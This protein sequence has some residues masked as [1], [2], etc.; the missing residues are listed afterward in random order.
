MKVTQGLLSL[1]LLAPAMARADGPSWKAQAKA[2]LVATTGN[3]QTTTL[4]MGATASRADD[5]NKFAV[6]GQLAYGR[7]GILVV[8]DD[9]D[10]V[11][12]PGEISRETRT[13]ANAWTTKARYD[14]TFGP[15]HG[16]FVAA[17]LGADAP[18]GKDL[19]SGGQAGYTQRLRKGGRDELVLEAGYDF[20]YENYSAPGAESVSIHSARVLVGETLKIAD[21]VG[22]A[23]SVE[24]LAN[25]NAEKGP[26]ARDPGEEVKLFRDIRVNG[27]AA[28]TAKLL[29][30]LSFSLGFTLRYDANPA[31]LPAIPE[32]PP[33][34]PGFVPFADEIDTVTDA[35]L[36]VTFL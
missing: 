31:P 27:K 22:L 14:R 6:E 19:A 32:A 12:E 15:K 35:A 36:I 20:S 18:G 24:A 34:A 26:N 25:L 13:T 3:A 17:L 29:G 10:G 9:G 16:F 11:T 1:A 7:S 23:A 30:N 8:V 28:L 4:T 2:G 21:G 33:F 5:G